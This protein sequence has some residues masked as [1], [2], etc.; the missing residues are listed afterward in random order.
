MTVGAPGPDSLGLFA[1]AQR[2][3]EDTETAV[4]AAQDAALPDGRGIDS[5]VLVGEGAAG[6]SAEV[7]AATSARSATVPVVFAAHGDIPAFAGP[8]TLVVRIEAAAVF[9]GDDEVALGIDVPHPRAAL[10]A[11]CAAPLTV[12][13][14][15]GILPGVEEALDRAIV[16]LHHRRAELF[17]PSPRTGAGPD[18]AKL[19]RRIGRLLPLVYGEGWAGAL[20]AT[21]WKAQCN[22]NAKSPAFARALPDLAHD[23]IAGWGQHG[24]LTRQVFCAV[25]LRHDHEAPGSDARFVTLT[26][27]LEESVSTVH[28]VAAAGEG[29]LA[30][31]LDLGYIG[32]VVSLHLAFQ[33][34]LDPGPAPALDLLR[35]AS[36]Y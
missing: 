12:L 30:Q 25:V 33:E 15:L 10:G 32:D 11:L 14:R 13:G 5:V 16:Q 2:V 22:V 31:L 9:V 4:L 18:A 19:A 26:D 1:A 7:V 35:P 27:V 34:G 17:G 28:A 6:W 20:A 23:E 21:R 29:V 24:D 8:S 3:P 36:E